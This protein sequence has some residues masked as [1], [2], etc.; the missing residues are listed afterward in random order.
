MP[1]EPSLLTRSEDDRRELIVWAVACAERVLP[2]FEAARPDDPRPRDALVGALEFSRNER[3]IGS[4]R[5]LAVSCHAAAR[6]ATLP[7]A[8]AAARACGHAVAVAHM[9]SH[10]RGVPLYALRAVALAHPGEPER[11]LVEDSWQR[12]H[13]PERFALYVYPAGATSD[14]A[15]LDSPV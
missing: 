10:A 7:S 14:P 2:I 8:V 11:V 1:R 5:S 6:G 4:A 3:R 12:S 15:E 9:G 13:V